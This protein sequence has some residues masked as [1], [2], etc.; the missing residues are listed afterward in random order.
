MTHI[1]DTILDTIGKTP[2]VKIGHLIDAPATVLAKMEPFNPL[3]SVKDRIGRSMIE[4]AEADGTL[5]PGATVI[6]PTSGNTGIGL[7][8]VCGVKG[9]PCVLTTPESASVERR[10]VMRALGASVV[11]TPAAGGMSGAIEKA[12]QMTAEMPGSFMPMQFDNPAN[13]QTHFETTG[14]EIWAD[15]NGQ[16]DVFVAGVGTGGTI[17]GVGRFLKQQN[18]NVKIIAIEPVESPVLTQ[19]RSGVPLAPGSHKIQGIGA[20]FVPGVLDMDLIDEV[21]TVTGE[22]SIAC[23]RLAAKE[24]GL[25][26][27]IS[28]GAALKAAS[29]I[30]QRPEMAGKTIVTVLPSFGERYLSSPLFAN[31]TEDA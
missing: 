19:T 5:K 10:K 18:P 7:A 21:I 8:F 14:P 30:A 12:R 15:A 9:Y 2:L 22:D 3:G 16:V 20:G 26:V 24:E 27:G 4:A 28:S 17:T 25:F 29:E 13:P 31:L 23:A 11:L 6:E 1:N